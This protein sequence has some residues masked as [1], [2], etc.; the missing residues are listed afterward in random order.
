MNIE[1]GGLQEVQG[2]VRTTRRPDQ[3][4]SCVSGGTS[5]LSSH[6][7]PWGLHKCFC[8]GESPAYT[9]EEHEGGLLESWHSLAL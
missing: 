1:A 2:E 8:H 3:V 4:T 5:L 7:C 6:F 9:E